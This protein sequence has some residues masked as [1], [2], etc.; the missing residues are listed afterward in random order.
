MTGFASIDF[1]GE[2]YPVILTFSWGMYFRALC[3]YDRLFLF[4]E[5]VVSDSSRSITLMN[6][7]KKT[8]TYITEIQQTVL[9]FSVNRL[10]ETPD[11][12]S[13]PVRISKVQLHSPMSLQVQVFFGNS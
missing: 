4:H 7:S 11:F 6:P 1:L 9:Y 10:L 2:Q 3:I 8:L 5:L 13:L 12:S